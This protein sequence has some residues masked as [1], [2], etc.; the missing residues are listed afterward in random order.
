VTTA[1]GW[2]AGCFTQSLRHIPGTR[3]PFTI[4][5]A[6]SGATRVALEGDLD[7]FTAD[8]LWFELLAVIRRRPATVELDLSR[9]RSVGA[10]AMEVLGAFFV[11]LTE[12]ACRVTVIEMRERPLQWRHVATTSI[13]HR[14]R[15]LN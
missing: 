4:A 5:P 11:G 14:S 12:I 9:V 6:A 2:I 1:G 8:R 10:R 15:L 13:R 3:M 7:V